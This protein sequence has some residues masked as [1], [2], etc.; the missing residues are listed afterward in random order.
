MTPVL[1]FDNLL[2][3][4]TEFRKVF[5][6][7]FPVYYKGKLRNSQTGESHRA[8]YGSWG[9]CVQSFHDLSRELLFQYLHVLANQKLITCQEFLQILISRS[10]SYSWMLVGG[11]ESS[12]SNHL[13]FLVTR[14]ILSL[15]RDP[16]PSYFISINSDRIKRGSL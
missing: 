10:P 8:M 16:I 14:P 15:P 9:V 11:S 4:L 6:L 2:E 5:Y 7:Y 13:V 3:W 12:S 1:R